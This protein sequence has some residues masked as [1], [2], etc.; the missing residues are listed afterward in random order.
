MATKTRSDRIKEFYQSERNRTNNSRSDRIN[1]FYEKEKK[2]DTR[3]SGRPYE[4]T[5]PTN[6]PITVKKLDDDDEDSRLGSFFKGTAKQL[7]GSNLSSIGTTLQ[8]TNPLEV[9]KKLMQPGGFAKFATEEIGDRITEKITGKEKEPSG[10]DNVFG[11][12]GRNLTSKADQML[13]SGAAD[14]EKSKEGLGTLGKF[15]IDMASQ[16]LLMGSD[17]LINAIAPGAGMAAFYSRAAG[18]GA[19]EARQAGAT[20]DQQLLYGAASGLLEVGLEKVF[21]AGKYLKG[22][23]GK[24]AIDLAEPIASKVATSNLVK[25][26]AKSKQGQELIFQLTKMGVAANEEGIEEALSDLISPFLKR[27]IY[28][29]EIEM[30]SAGEVLYDYLLGAA[31]GG[32]FGVAGTV[33]D[34]KSGVGRLYQMESEAAQN[35]TDVVGEAINRAQVQGEKSESKTF[36]DQLQRQRESGSEVLGGQLNDLER[37][38]MSE[39]LKHET[40]LQ[41]QKRDADKEFYAGDVSKI[42]NEGS[43]AYNRAIT[44]ISSNLAKEESSVLQKKIDEN[45]DLYVGMSG[46]SATIGAIA[47][48]MIGTATTQDIDR[49]LMKPAAKALLRDSAGMDIPVA[50]TEARKTIES[51][52]SIHGAMNRADIRKQAK[53]KMAEDLSQN[54]GTEG[55]KTFVDLYQN[56]ADVDNEKFNSI[57]DRYYNAGT[58]N[59][60]VADMDRTVSGMSEPYVRVAEKYFTPEVKS[61]IMAAGF[62][63]SRAE[64]MRN[65]QSVVRRKKSSETSKKGVLRDESSGKLSVPMKTALEAFAQRTGVNVVYTDTLSGG[66]ANGAYDTQSNGAYINGTIYLAADSANPLIT[67]AKHELTHHLKKFAPAEYQE[68]EDFVFSEW[69]K[70]DQAAHDRAIQDKIDEYKKAG[71]ELTR[72]EAKEEILADAAEAFFRDESAIDSAIAYSKKLGE[73]I[74]EGIRSLLDTFIAIKDSGGEY[75]EK[76]YGDF[77]KQLNILEEAQHKW[78]K[79]LQAST[80]NDVKAGEDSVVKKSVKE[81]DDDSDSIREQIRKY[82]HIISKMD[83]VAYVT[84]ESIK[85]LNRSEKAKRIMTDYN[86]K[87]KGGIE[88]EGLGYI[89]LNEDLVVGALKYLHTD[90]EYAAFKALPQVLKRGHQV[91]GHNNHKHRNY[92]TVTIIAPVVINEQPGNMGVVVKLAGKKRYK[93]HRILAPDGS[94]FILK[95]KTEPIG[96]GVRSVSGK[97]GSAIGSDST[98]IVTQESKKINKKFSLKDTDD[99]ELSAGQQKFFKNSKVRDEQ[100]RLKVMY[101]G[102]SGAGFTVFDS[103]YS[104]DGRSFFFTDKLDVASG[105]SASDQIFTPKEFKSPDELTT[106]IE[107]EMGEN[108]EIRGDEGNYELWEDGQFA[109]DAESLYDLYWE[110]NDYTGFGGDSANYQVYL[111]LQNPLVIDAD[112]SNWDEIPVEWTDDLMTTRAIAEYAQENGYDGVMIKNVIDTGIYGSRFETSDIAVAFNS[113]QIKSVNNQNPTKNDDIRFS[114]KESVEETK[115]LIAVHNMRLSELA[116]SLDLGGLPMPS[117][118]I[119]KARSGHNEYGDVSL[120]FSKE[121]IDPKFMRANKVYGGDAWTPTYPKIEY[122]VNPKVEKKISD[123]YYELSRKYGYDEVRPLYD[124]AT[125]IE[126]QL[127]RN[128]G[129]AGMIEN[130]Q[131]DTKMMQLYLLA[132][133]KGK[134][135]NVTKETITEMSEAEIEKNE[136]FVKTLGED[137]VRSFKVPDGMSPMTH[138]K[139]WIAEHKTELENMYSG[140]F[141]DVFGF[142]QEVINKILD[143]TKGLD[144]M[145]MMRDALYFIE[146]GTK[147]VNTEIDYQATKE[148]I[149]E[150]TADGYSDWLNDLFSGVEEK[151]GIRNNADPF[152]RSGNRRSWEALHWENN[153]ENVVKLMKQEENGTGFFGGSGI[154]GVSAKEYKSIDEIRA[155]SVRLEKMDEEQYSKIKDELGQRFSEI[156]NSIMDK[157]NSNHFIAVDNAMECIVDA[158]R[159]SKTKSGIMNELKQYRQLTV[160][161]QNVDDIVRLVSDIANMPTEYFEAKP[162]RAVGLDEIKAVIIPD[163]ADAALLSKL[164]EGGYNVIQYEAGNA[165]DRTKKLNSIED[166]KFQ[167]KDADT[168]SDTERNVARLEDKVAKLRSEFKRTYLKTP[169]DVDVNRQA[170]RLIKR[171]DSNLTLHPKLV[172]AMRDIF[173]IYKTNDGDWGEAYNIAEDA[174][175]QIVDKIAVLHDESWREYKDLRTHL[176]NVPVRVSEADRASMTDYSAFRKA[177]FGRIKLTNDQGLSVDQYYQALVEQWPDKFTDDYVTASDQL[178]HIADVLDSLAPWYETY[179]SA[180]MQDFVTDIAADIMETA[181][182]LQTRKTFAD[183]KAEEKAAAVAKVKAQR[184]AAMDKLQER[185]E[186]KLIRQKKVSREKMDAYKEKQKDR[187]SRKKAMER[188]Q[189]SYKWLNERLLNPSDTKHIPESYR[190]A[191][192]ELLSGFDFETD[193]SAAYAEKNGP[194]KKTIK[195]MKFMSDYSE[196]MKSEEGQLIEFDPDIIDT[197]NEIK[198]A[199]DG[200]RLAD[201]DTATLDKVSRLLKHIQHQMSYVNRCFSEEIS[202]TISELGEDT[203][204]GTRAMKK[205]NEYVGMRKLFDD[206]LNQLNVTPSDMFELI[207]GPMNTLYQQLRKGMDRHIINL[208]VAKDYVDKVVDSKK[209]D[210]WSNEVHKIRTSD[211]TLEITTSQIMSLYALMQRKQAQGHILGSGIVMAPVEVKD[212]NGLKSRSKRKIEETKIIP[213][214][215]DVTEIIS[216]LT[217]EQR[218]VADQ[219]RSFLGNECSE[220]GNRTS[221]KLYGYKKFT[222]S[223]YFPIKSSNY[224]LNENFD[225]KNVESS[226]KNMG[227]T[228]AIVKE[229][230]NPIVIDDIFDVF[231]NHVSKMSMYEALVPAMTD[232]QRVY[233]YRSKNIEGKQNNSVQKALSQAFGRKTTEYIKR[234]MEDINGQA[235]KNDSA[236]AT[237]LMALYKKASIGGNIRV[238]LQQPTAIVR[239]AAVMNPKYLLSVKPATKSDIAEMQMHCPIAQWKSWGFYNTDVSRSFKD[240]MFGK[241]NLIDSVFMGSYGKADDFTWACIWKAVKREVAEKNPD[242]EKGSDAYWQKVNERASYVYD[243]TQVVDSVFHRSQIMRNKGTFEK[244]ATSFMAEPTKTYNMMRTEIILARRENATGQRTAAAERMGRVLSVY[245][246]NAITVSMA[247]AIADAM[248]GAGGDDEEDKGNFLQRWWAHTKANFVDNANPLNL[249]PYVKDVVSLYSGY[250]VARMD[251]QAFSKLMQVNSMWEGIANGSSKYST[252]HVMRKTA[253]AVSYFTGLP[254]RNLLRDAE[255]LAKSIAEAFGGGTEMKYIS[256]KLMYALGPDSGNRTIFADLYYDALADSNTEL[257]NEI[258]G[259]MISKGVDSDYIKRRKKKWEENRNS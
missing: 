196:I 100:G 115:D 172:N 240:I 203:I 255:G 5:N 218:E 183:R 205:S 171:Y 190:K 133:G 86:K 201:L 237:N 154:Y 8:S 68:L 32:L 62:A 87:F 65:E 46:D 124:Y 53:V 247:A 252:A 244:M 35:G 55:S 26:I 118:A 162:Q 254:V 228:K 138:R 226:L 163:D 217:D 13:E 106:Y 107:E 60:G 176:K 81:N 64:T 59:I 6:Q 207:G 165:E 92:S 202:K 27:A 4:K 246:L 132:S 76:G 57:F 83:P 20:E 238:L 206:L 126:E 78:M 251:T 69:F 10:S 142:D 239:A 186:Q 96:A 116:K 145:K 119:I 77:L 188:L 241:E 42:S 152:T 232:F 159:K 236:I 242:L 122:K 79:A 157:S 28:A 93:M 95:E 89:E 169:K 24:G 109:V 258:R 73:A 103:Q 61:A 143:G 187:A 121:T 75:R 156:A 147:T 250:D 144:Y 63:D 38:T 9:T 39:Q 120:V 216:R 54:L 99:R 140:Y 15:G 52:V 12:I 49:V 56:V 134:V 29:D 195:F 208:K 51:L 212:G 168:D 130:L 224:F 141:S 245:L 194:S 243:R 41:R 153:L 94:E 112:A 36:A 164:Q 67:V 253:E 58:Y 23:Y 199:I 16:G 151:S 227:F 7:A 47:K 127:N 175:R 91:T 31:S 2:T 105:Y 204:N 150:K 180:E 137:V 1:A 44:E 129:A 248:R 66:N 70:G 213:E 158:V 88:V 101:H 219:L 178:Y 111:N 74:L 210:E 170:T 3:F 160:T 45:P 25:G 18:Y 131:D 230:S 200:K 221:M 135:E 209:M 249:V 80:K 146:N 214:L 149:I 235:A 184:D 113:N 17:A 233:N 215:D 174:A 139:S 166:V 177:N 179:D 234:F 104:D 136:Y 117:I 98:N 37:M 182:N 167:L 148:K 155:D 257:A 14:L 211:G 48:V 161:E 192:A 19:N 11:A 223:D 71:Y 222:E 256:A 22:M 102:S 40:E 72:A 193:R 84:Y 30:P 90:G 173:R 125:D 259:Y 82:Q 43:V 191:I 85:G 181:Y 225:T 33:A 34:Y 189:K 185:Y 21:S 97:Q 231:T 110:Y 128:N 220:W 108:V 50:N 114:L 197:M 229:A 123:L 198:E